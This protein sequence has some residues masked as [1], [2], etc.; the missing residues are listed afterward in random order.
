MA[1]GAYS[2]ATRWQDLDGLGHDNH[3]AV[4]T[5]LEEGRDAFLREH[6]IGREE[7]VVGRCAVEFRGEIEPG[8]EAVTV[9]CGVLELGNKSVRTVERIL[10]PGG[11]TVVEA[12]FGIVLWDPEARGT[13]AIT[14]AERAS[15]SGSEVG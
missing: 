2:V 7:Y 6:G 14:D 8:H 12:E 5:Y 13:R 4:F 11:E 15:L 10:A 9:E 1:A 3:A